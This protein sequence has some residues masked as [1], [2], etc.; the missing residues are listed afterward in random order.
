M[1]TI[2]RNKPLLGTF[3]EIDIIADLPEPALLDLST[4]AFQEIEKIQ[5]LM[6]FHDPASELSHI[7]KAAFK[8]SIPLSRPMADVIHQALHLSQLT[9][10]LYDITVV[11][12]LMRHGG[13]PRYYASDEQ[14]AW[15]DISITDDVIR[16]SKDIKIDLGGIAKG[17]AVDRAMD[18]LRAQ[19]VNYEQI[20]INAGGD[21]RLLNWQNRK[22]DIRHPSPKLRGQFITVNMQAPAVATSAPSYTNKNSLIIHPNTGMP[23]TSKDSISVFAPTCMTADMLTKALFLVSEKGKLLKRFGASAVSVDQKGELHQL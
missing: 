12:P 18:F 2:S 21:L 23:I 3:V 7:N 4:L 10:G 22:A 11:P 16:F 15:H 6:S 19:P 9:G 14:G 5:D 20:S 13:L 17:Y 8:T 1:A